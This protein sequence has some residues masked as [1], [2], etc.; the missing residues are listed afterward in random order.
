ME[1]RLGELLF[2]LFLPNVTFGFSGSAFFFL[3]GGRPKDMDSGIVEK[4]GVK[5]IF[6]SCSGA[7]VLSSSRASSTTG[8]YTCLNGRFGSLAKT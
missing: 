4:P 3:I 8:S 7:F 1:P 2:D 6:V 5:G